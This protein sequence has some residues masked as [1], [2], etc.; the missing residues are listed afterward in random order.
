MSLLLMS[1]SF[2]VMFWFL[3][4]RASFR[5]DSLA[6]LL[7]LASPQRTSRSLIKAAP[8]AKFAAELLE[9]YLREAASSGEIPPS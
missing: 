6:E 5:S 1:S 4:L 8:L 7:L 2:S 3:P 9:R